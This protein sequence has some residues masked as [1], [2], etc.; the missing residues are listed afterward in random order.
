MLLVGFTVICIYLVEK[1]GRSFCLSMTP[2]S[3]VYLRL[4]NRSNVVLDILFT[5]RNSI[6]KGK[7]LPRHGTSDAKICSFKERK[8]QVTNALAFPCYK[9]KVGISYNNRLKFSRRT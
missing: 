1:N 4:E 8:K 3:S 5:N 9:E 2:K 6:L 7:K